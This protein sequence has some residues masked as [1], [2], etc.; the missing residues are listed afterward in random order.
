[1]KRSLQ[2]FYKAFTQLSQAVHKAFKGL[3]TRFP[4]V[5][6]QCCLQ[7]FDNVLYK[8]FTMLWQGF[9]KVFSMLL[10]GLYKAFNCF[11][12]LLQG[13]CKAHT[14]CLQCALQGFYKAFT[15][16]FTRLLQC[17]LHSFHNIF[18]MFCTMFFCCE[19]SSQCFLFFWQGFTRLL[20]CFYRAFIRL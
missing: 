20:Q 9:Y 6:L 5:C 13:F 10:Q 19:A 2:G 16:L 4:H 15:K 12:R 3:F 7:D 1:M 18:H 11:I 17:V 8:A 14:R